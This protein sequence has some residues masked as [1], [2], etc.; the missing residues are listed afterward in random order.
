MI[1]VGL[2]LKKLFFDRI[3]VIRRIGVQRANFLKRVGFFTRRV[4]IR[5]QRRAGK[6]AKSSTPPAPP[7]FHANSESVS[8]RNIQFSSIFGGDGIV[9]G[10]VYLNAIHGDSTGN[11]SAGTVPRTHEKGGVIGH[12]E[13]FKPFT[14]EAARA[15]FGELE[16]NNWI[17]HFGVMPEW[18]W[19]NIYG[20]AYVDAR[21]DQSRKGIWVPVGRRRVDRKLTR[22]RN[23]KYPARPIMKP[24][25]K[26]ASD[27]FKELWF[28]SGAAA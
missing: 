3:E 10:P 9:I 16:G 20:N 23:A 6:K 15:A 11:L 8:L 12:R 13:K 5:G 24:A 4:A 1:T 7:T 21:K 2:R 28:G 19:R 27:K 14:H 26:A 25:V 22:V 17:E 18:Q